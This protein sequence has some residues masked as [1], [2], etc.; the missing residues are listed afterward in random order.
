MDD[1][2]FYRNA[3]KPFRWRRLAWPLFLPRW[4]C[5]RLRALDT[6]D[7]AP[8]FLIGYVIFARRNPRPK[9][10]ASSGDLRVAGWSRVSL[11]AVSGTRILRDVSNA[12]HRARS[13]PASPDR[14]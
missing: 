10:R 11:S 14:T 5:F 4:F 2:R 1:F 9:V 6:K 3:P 8:K 7:V 13:L 12:S